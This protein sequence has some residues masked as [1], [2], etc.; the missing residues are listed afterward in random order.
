M[1]ILALL[2]PFNVMEFQIAAMLKMK[3][4]VKVDTWNF[5]KSSVNINRKLC[6]TSQLCSYCKLS[7]IMIKSRVREQA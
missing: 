1:K 4:L 7:D 2:E 5:H 3:N 6:Y